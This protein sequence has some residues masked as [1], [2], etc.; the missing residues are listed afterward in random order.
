MSGLA[1]LVVAVY[2]NWTNTRAKEIADRT[3]QTRVAIELVN[4]REKSSAELRAQMF[5]AL[6]QN[7]FREASDR[8][9]IVI[10]ELIALNF[11][12]AVQIKPMLEL[13]DTQFKEMPS[14]PEREKLRVELRRASRVVIRDQLE[15]I[16]LSRDGDV[17]EAKIAVGKSEPMTCG[18]DVQLRVL[19]IEDDSAVTVQTEY[20]DG[21]PRGEPFQLSY[22]DMPMVDY[23]TVR[24]AGSNVWRYAVVL[25]DVASD[26]KY[27]KIGIACLP[28]S[29]VGAE[30]R[31]AFDELLEQYLFPASG[32]GS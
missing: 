1:T 12:D 27:A 9:Q 23:K 14:S 25:Q 13:L 3:E 29:Q 8:E 15:Q 28:V 5:N 30:R 31:Y 22:F 18:P 2:T 4:A 32:A 21:K 24:S 6:L 26:L 10:L 17:N 16:R 20:L 7:Y 11:R 19:N